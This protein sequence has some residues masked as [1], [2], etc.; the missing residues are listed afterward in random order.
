MKRSDCLDISCDHKEK[1]YC[2]MMT[3]AFCNSYGKSLTISCRR[4]HVIFSFV[5]NQSSQHE[6]TV[7][8]QSNNANSS[9]QFLDV[10]LYG[11]GIGI[12]F[13][14]IIF[15]AFCKLTDVFD[16]VEE[17][18]KDEMNKA[19]ENALVMFYGGSN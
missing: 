8:G 2:Y 4:I 12:P 5:H 14:N 13:K 3:Q 1:G 15:E 7:Y 19:G 17:I 16:K 10:L 18:S 9:M 11:M 6:K